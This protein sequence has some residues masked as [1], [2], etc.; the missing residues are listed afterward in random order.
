MPGPSGDRAARAK[1]V[2]LE[3]L[4][5]LPPVEVPGLRGR[6]L[7]FGIPVLVMA[8]LAL[9]YAG[10]EDSRSAKAQAE[11]RALR[12]LAGFGEAAAQLG[13]DRSAELQ[14]S[15]ARLAGPGSPLSEV[16]M[17]TERQAGR[18][19]F[20]KARTY[21]VHSDPALAGQ[22][23]DPE[24]SRDKR[25]YD[26]SK[27]V[28]RRHE[29]H[30]ADRPDLT[31]VV[32]PVAG[33]SVDAA[34]PVLIDGK[35]V[36]TVGLRI[37]S[38]RAELALPWVLMLALLLGAVAA[39]V[40]VFAF[41]PDLRVQAVA[42]FAIL[43]AAGVLGQ[44]L[45]G[46]TVD[47]SE[48]YAAQRSAADLAALHLA[49]PASVDR[50]ALVAKMAAVDGPGLKVASVA[51]AT[52]ASGS[53][54]PLLALSPAALPALGSPLE[55]VTVTQAAAPAPAAS[56]FRASLA[57]SNG[58]TAALLGLLFFLGFIGY[59]GRFLRMVR[60]HAFAYGY[61][62][63]SVVGMILFVFFP[64]ISGFVFSFFEYVSGD[65]LVGT[66][67]MF[68]MHFRFVG[69][70]HFFDILASNEYSFT[71]GRNFYFTL[72]VTILWTASNVALH[73]GIGLAL[74]MLLKNPWLKLK[75]IYRVLLIVPW[76][77]PNY[78]TAL[79][80]RGMFDVE[81]GTVNFVLQA[82]GLGKVAWWSHFW[83]AFTANLTTNVWLGF[84]FMMVISLGAL[85]SIPSDLYEAADV[86]GASRWQQF[87][88]ITLPLLKPALFPAIILGTIWTF[89]MFN[90]IYL[91]S[92]GAPE[93]TTDIL[94]TEAYRFAFEGGRRYGYAA[95]YSVIIFLILLVYS[96]FTNRMT[97]ASEGSFD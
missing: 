87:R 3:Q 12:L 1:E 42:G 82:I 22:K 74:A 72:L 53:V 43:I 71:D 40:L 23:L 39:G 58:W 44:S 41:I 73:A 84:P 27:E 96:T 32:Q 78:I 14:A 10:V 48:R 47:A 90:V 45:V 16:W 50:A 31:Y 54:A 64:F 55:G 2:A 6:A 11:A 29:K 61:A 65:D 80:W 30:G 81:Y 24:Q 68:D 57:K 95:A 94:I 52:S 15:V 36:G 70:K 7:A 59:V 62:A 21:D 35:L 85:Q 97:K 19:V 69:L 79:I 63:P 60:D 25:P 28:E 91:V 38:Q 86:D 93:H 56:P 49:L 67:T 4:K 5:R 26:L 8:L 75:G 13:L 18:F 83:S 51:G 89:N 46:R 34:G 37:S 17:I 66:V 33:E 20:Q 88:H 9:T 77:V 76:A 92:G